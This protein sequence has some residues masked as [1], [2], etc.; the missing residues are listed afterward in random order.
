MR[1]DQFIVSQFNNMISRK[2]SNNITTALAVHTD[3]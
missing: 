2:N 1:E 3:K